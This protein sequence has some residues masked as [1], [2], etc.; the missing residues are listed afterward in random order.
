VDNL[1]PDNE[2]AAAQDVFVRLS[3]RYEASG[4]LS[5]AE[6]RAALVG[7]REGL[8]ARAETF[9]KAICADFGFR[10]RH[11]TLLTEVVVV[12]Q[13][14]D[15][16]MPRM[17]R[18]ARPRRLAL[19]PP[20]WPARAQI[21]P[22]PRGLA[23]VMGPSNYPLQLALMPLIGALSAGC[24]TLIK[25]S[26]M[27]P[28]TADE[29]AALVAAHLDPG[30]VGV[31]CGGPALG[32]HLAS[33]PFGIILFT[34]S[35]GVGARIAS[36]AAP[37]LTPV[38]LELGGKAPAILDRDA[39]LARAT[40][41][42]IAGKLLNAGQ[43]C[44]A[45]DY[46][47]A[48]ADRFADTVAGLRAAALK[49]YPDAERRDYT[50]VNSESAKARLRSLEA[51]L[52]VQPLFDAPSPRYRP[53]LVLNPP[54]DHAIM[55]EE[56]FGPLLP[57]IPYNQIEDA[58]AIVRAQPDP[59]ALY[60]FGEK[61][62]RY[63]TVLERTRSGAVAVNETVLQAGVSQLPFGGVGAS[64]YGR[65]HGREGFDAFSHE[66]VVFEQ[67]R[68]SLT[69][70]LRPPYGARADRILGFLIGAAIKQT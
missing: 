43:T 31:V 19:A 54:R 18:W 14:I 17:G 57:V 37:H 7:L 41:T 35:G 61:N 70:L 21:L 63:R 9:A 58:I 10:S 23:C 64:G 27:T 38:I 53:A 13:A 8:K 30:A 6:R 55:R 25:P 12:L 67:S 50:S 33:L 29:I 52:D 45:P 65:Y 16:T 26:E 51:G 2:I 49:L 40:E 28:R 68:F 1:K 4:G 66:R 48:P 62:A 42:I 60:W 24:P 11:E 3:R 22:T 20:V 32:A 69:R 34:G 44:V 5:L 59:L 39:N 15:Y 47:L 46:V 36:A 56:I